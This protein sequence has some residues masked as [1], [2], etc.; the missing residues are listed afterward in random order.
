[1]ATEVTGVSLMTTPL[2]PPSVSGVSL[3]FDEK[4]IVSVTG[5]SL[6]ISPI[7]R[8]GGAFRYATTTLGEQIT[9]QSSSF[10][11]CGGCDF[12]QKVFSLA[13]GED[14]QNDKSSFITA[15]S[16]STDTITYK[17]FRDGLEV[18]TITDDSLGKYY[19][20]F[21]SNPLYV[22]FV[23]DWQLIEDA[24]GV[25]L[26]Q[27]KTE[28]VILGVSDTL[29]SHKFRL[30]LY[31]DQL[32]DNTIK[33]QAVHNGNL[34][35]GINYIDLLPDGW[36]EE[37]RISGRFVSKNAVSETDIYRS[38]NNIVKQIQGRENAEY[39]LELD[40]LPIEVWE[41]IIFIDVMATEHFYVTDYNVRS[42]VNK[43][44]QS[45]KRLDLVKSETEQETFADSSKFKMT[46]RE[47]E[48]NNLMSSF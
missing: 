21:A 26:Y 44:A 29:E 14:Y 11:Y 33:I 43:K 13:G 17:L 25:G 46:F 2:T 41:R 34:L 28:R 24:H 38:N 19:S 10:C 36:I 40:P 35:S 3:V 48:E 5:V 8:S 45:F 27:V 39:I 30:R 31:N 37:Y 4:Q 12:E 15:K 42:A 32:A 9:Q 22:G 18:A 7:L 20:T 6:I 16:I 23:A 47:R 1:M